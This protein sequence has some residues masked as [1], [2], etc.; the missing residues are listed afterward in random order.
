MIRLAAVLVALLGAVVRPV[1]AQWRAV[2]VLHRPPSAEWSDA[3][4][5]SCPGAPLS[6]VLAVQCKGATRLGGIDAPR[7]HDQATGRDVRASGWAIAASAAL[8]GAGQAL[9][10]VDRFL[11]YAALEA[12]L[13]IQYA[14]HSRDA[15]RERDAY[16]WLAASVARSGPPASLPQGDFEYYERM[17]HYAESGRF[18]LATGG[19]LVPET[20]TTTYNGAMWLLAR[21]TYWPDAN[22][23][24]D[25]SS[26]EWRL[27]VDFYRRRS[28][29]VPYLWS[30]GATPLE[31][32]EFRR[33]IGR[34]NAS[35]RKALQDV[36]VILANHLLST[37]DAL[38]TVRLRRR[39]AANHQGAGWDVVGSF[40]LSGIGR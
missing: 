6:T 15:R 10:G 37:V 26:R 9:L 36:G 24:P 29:D 20:D 22:T 8:P 32:G 30:W 33:L 27:A 25:T 21:R 31:Y 18:T 39:P 16:R 17:K 11:P 23:P 19:E 5:V 13:W 40:P 1:L 3:T 38:V 7:T 2:P 28:Y 35:N 14:S 34:S 12:Y 4:D